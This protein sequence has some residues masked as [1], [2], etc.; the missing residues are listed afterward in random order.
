MYWAQ[1]YSMFNRMRR[2][3]PGTDVIHVAMFQLIYLGG[4][5]YSLGSLTWSN[6]F[7]DGFPE[8]ALV[9]NLIALG[10]SVVMALLPY[11]AIFTLMFEE[12][13]VLCLEYDK[14]RILLPSEYD[15]LNPSTAKEGYKDYM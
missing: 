14:N 4:I 11:R 8:E 9:P 6:F 13:Q 3:V 7:P 10:I 1:K 15:R 5:F 12:E 2:P